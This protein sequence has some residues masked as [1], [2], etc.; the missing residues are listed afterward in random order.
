MDFLQVRPGKLYL[1]RNNQHTQ[2]YHHIPVL[3]PDLVA[4]PFFN[5]FSSVTPSLDSYFFRFSKLSSLLTL[6]FLSLF[7]V[8]LLF[9]ISWLGK[10]SLEKFRKLPLDLFILI[11]IQVDTCPTKKSS[12][13]RGDSWLKRGRKFSE[14][15][16]EMDKER[17][18]EKRKKLRRKEEETWMH[19][20]L[21]RNSK[22][23]VIYWLAE[24]CL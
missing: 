22:R 8:F 1:P 2:S 14:Q 20:I 15:E 11:L 4:P 10:F 18:I 13:R 17:N 6:K 9:N 5:V 24:T 16:K 21:R 12:I 23:I 19:K 3:V 7:S